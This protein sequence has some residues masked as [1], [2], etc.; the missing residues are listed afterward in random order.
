MPLNNT[1]K[2]FF[3]SL[4]EEFKKNPPKPL[5]EQTIDE[6]RK[7]GKA[8]FQQ[9]TADSVDIASYD[10]TISGPDGN[11]ITM[12]IYGQKTKEKTPVLIFYPGG[13]FIAELGAHAA[14]CSRIAAETGYK[15][16][17]PFCRL[18]PEHK[19]PSGLNDAYAT[20]NHV[21]ENADE[22]GVDCDRIAIG[23]DSSGG[24]FAALIAIKIRDDS[25]PLAHQFL[26]SPAV[27][28]S[29]TITNN[30]KYAALKKCEEEDILTSSDLAH[31][32]YDHYLPK[33]LDRK[34]PSTS[35][36]FHPN[37]SNLAP[38]TII[39]AEYDGLRADA[40][41]YHQQLIDSD[42][43]SELF[44]CKGQ[45]HSFLI[46]RK[47]LNEGT[48]PTNIVIRRMQE[49]FP[50]ENEADTQTTTMVR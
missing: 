21:L 39:V 4:M 47:V 9:L 8:L 27:D 25:K 29:R 42:N 7:N 40:D 24:N 26:I 10:H 50:A 13:A 41:A 48:D 31:W 37:L 43:S 20:Y 6:Y 44:V 45:T 1:I 15:V 36:Y 2:K 34:D 28:L 22:L 19:F 14:T 33:T 32:A 35:P 3:T 5:S 49:I 11:T 17:M 23:G 16:I 12:R 38:A 18:A 30:P 46:A